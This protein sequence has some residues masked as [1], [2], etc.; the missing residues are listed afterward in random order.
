MMDSNTQQI[1]IRDYVD[2]ESFE[3]VYPILCQLKEQ[4]LSPTYV[5]V[6]GHRYVIEAFRQTWPSVVIQRCLYHIQREGMRW[7]RTFP[8]TEA[9]R[10]LR[11]IVA[12]VTAV[13]STAGRDRFMA[14]FNQWQHRYGD[15]VRSLPRTTVAF[16]D[17]KRTVALIRNAAK[18]MFHY[19]SDPRIRS[20][21]N[22]LESFFSRLKADYQR[23][24]G[25]SEKHKLSY[26]QWYCYFHNRK[27]STQNEY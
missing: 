4:G 25:L 12:T 3:S 2:K 13:R 19:L 27:T 5:T 18:D 21:T 9:G 20:T 17:L 16:K 26:L 7:L 15:F 22:V 8:K 24:R 11:A 1:L 6:D 14:Q 10:A 23:H